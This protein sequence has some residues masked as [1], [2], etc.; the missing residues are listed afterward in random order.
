[1][2]RM[3]KDYPKPAFGIQEVSVRGK[4]VP[5]VE[6]TVLNRPF[7]RLQCFERSSEQAAEQDRLGQD[8]IALVVAPLSGHHAT[9]LRDTVRAL[10]S[11]HQVYITDW[12]DARLVPRAAGPFTLDDYVGYVRDFMRHIGFER[13]HVIS[14]CQPCVP[15]LAAAALQAAAGQPVPRTLTMMGGPIDARCHPTRVNDLATNRSLHWFEEHVLHEVPAKYPGRGRR[16]Y[17]GFLQHAGFIAMNPGRHVGSHWDFYRHL[18]E[19]DLE[20]AEAHRRFYDEYNAVLDLP[21]EYYMDCIRIVFKEHLLPRG[22]W[23]VAGERVAP[24]AL[25]STALLTIE[26]QLDDISGLGQTRA[27]LDLCSGIP[28]ARRHHLMVEGAGHYGIFSGRRWRESVYPRVREFIATGGDLR[29]DE[30]VPLSSA[31]RSRDS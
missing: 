7:C 9:L 27:A 14:V 12:L 29:L 26:G 2:F 23:S 5:V 13:L 22:L 31:P 30:V 1:M 15:V 24:A 3:G 18:V 21:A 28:R 25:Q 8:P 16:V 17:P 11:D 10:L 6:R 4:R 20:D 19:G